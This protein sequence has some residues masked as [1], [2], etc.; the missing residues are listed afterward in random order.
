[1][2]DALVFDEARHAYTLD[3]APVP[4][5]TSVLK[6]CSA[7]D[8]A[9][10]DPEVMANAAARGQA[11][12]RLIELD[13]QGQL[14]E[15]ALDPM[16]RPYLAQWREF[17]AHS[18]F[19]PILQEHQ[20]A[21]RRYRYAGTL[22]LFGYLDDHLALI[23]AKSVAKLMRSTGPQTAAYELALREWC[24]AILPEGVPV[25][26]FALQLPKS[27]RW[28]LHPLRDRADQRVFLAARTVHHFT[29]GV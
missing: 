29:T 19:V 13:G 15:A 2:V 10:V 11:V 17:L 26:R 6:V 5:V 8:Y 20:V 14:D 27:G 1:M 3:G 21:S 16:L 9:G 7:A 4:G 23:D 12:H 22:D 18:G 25:R 28:Q 24:P